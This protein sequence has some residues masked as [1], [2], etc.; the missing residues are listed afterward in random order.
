MRTMTN[1][2]R[3]AV[4]LVSGSL[5]LCSFSADLRAQTWDA[6]ADWSEVSKPN[7]VWS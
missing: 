2:N 7:G 6:K 5:L 1:T 3:M 4:T